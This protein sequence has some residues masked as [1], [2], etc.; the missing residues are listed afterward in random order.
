MPQSSSDRNRFTQGRIRQAAK[1]VFS[2]VQQNQ[3]D[4]LSRPFAP[5]ISGAQAITQPSSNSIMAVNSCF[6][7]AANH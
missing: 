7:R 1:A 2:A 4:C 5:G 6:M 3:F